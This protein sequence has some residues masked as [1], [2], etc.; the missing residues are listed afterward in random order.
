M[1]YTGLRP[2]ECFAL[3]RSNIDLRNGYL[4]V[5]DEVGSSLTERKTIR[6][7]KT[8]ESNRKVPIVK[9]LSVI[10]QEWMFTN[11][12]EYLFCDKNGEFMDSTRIVR[13][14]NRISKK[15]EVKFNMYRLRHQFSTDLIMQNNDP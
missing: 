11:S 10:L 4:K 15:L 2:G 14:L 9:E 8:P 13:I 7:T 6:Q 1:Y 12:N 3:K 5:S